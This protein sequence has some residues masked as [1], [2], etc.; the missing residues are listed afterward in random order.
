V[1]ATIYRRPLEPGASSSCGRCPA[2]RST[3]SCS[4]TTRSR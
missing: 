2:L 1:N 4:A 3:T